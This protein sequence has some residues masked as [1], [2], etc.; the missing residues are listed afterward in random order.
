[1]HRHTHIF[2]RTQNLRKKVKVR[3]EV[4]DAREMI[5][6]LFRCSQNDGETME[7]C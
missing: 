1:M 5:L 4:A 3:Q 7:S 2:T 6:L